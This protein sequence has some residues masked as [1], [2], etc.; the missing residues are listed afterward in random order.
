M[1]GGIRQQVML[2]VVLVADVV[3]R[4]LTRRCDGVAAGLGGFMTAL[5]RQR[6]RE[7]GMGQ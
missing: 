4:V 5:E 2:G 3:D 6:E 1:N 7:Q